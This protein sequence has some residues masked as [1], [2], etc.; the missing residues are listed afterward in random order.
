[1]QNLEIDGYQFQFDASFGGRHA[2]TA[3]VC[4]CASCRNFAL[5]KHR[6]PASLVSF[7]AE[8]G[9][10]A[11]VPAD[12]FPVRFNPRQNTVEQELHYFVDGCFSAARPQKI[13]VGDLRVS[14]R[15]LPGRTDPPQFCLSVENLWI[16]W[17]I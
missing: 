5:Y 13:R 11:G 8:F 3:P 7:L 4:Q 17:S 10:D 2:Q 15:S 14:V 6:I 16:P 1:M 12:Q 9:L